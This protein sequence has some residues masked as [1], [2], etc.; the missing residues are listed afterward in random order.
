MIGS[1]RDLQ[2]AEQSHLRAELR[3]LAQQRWLTLGALAALWMAGLIVLS[4][5]SATSSPAPV[6]VN[7]EPG[8]QRTSESQPRSQHRAGVDLAAAAAVCTDLSRIT[9]T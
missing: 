3:A 2:A 5:R 8:T 9:T 7:D 4:R 6:R 1:L